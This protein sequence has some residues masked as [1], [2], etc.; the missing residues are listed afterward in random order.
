M[1]ST[2]YHA[3]TNARAK[4]VFQVL[5]HSAIFLLIAGTYTPFTLVT[6]GGGWGWSLF[7]LVWALAAAGVTFKC[8]FTGR[9][10]ILSTAIY[11]AMGWCVVIAL[12]PLVRA[13][14]AAGLVW[15]VAGGLAYTAGVFFFAARWRYAHAVWHACVLAGSVCHFCAVFGFVATLPA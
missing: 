10:Q 4:R 8:F 3:L 9:A 2:L 11:I 12:R 15:L 6:L 1:A 7:G 13:L 14:P 5:D